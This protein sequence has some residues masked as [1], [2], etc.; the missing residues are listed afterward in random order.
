[1][2]D[3]VGKLRRDLVMT[4]SKVEHPALVLVEVV[5]VVEGL[6]D[7]TPHHRVA[8][9]VGPPTCSSGHPFLP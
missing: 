3:L 8:V 4:F 5:E 2:R 1:M 7:S 9:V 6:E